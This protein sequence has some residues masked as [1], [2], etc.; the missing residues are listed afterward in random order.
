M[1][2]HKFYFVREIKNIKGGIHSAE[3]GE[4]NQLADLF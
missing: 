1:K 3:I 2:N 4:Y